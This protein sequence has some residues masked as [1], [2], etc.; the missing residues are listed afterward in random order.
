MH[1]LEGPRNGTRV[2]SG[3][4]AKIIDTHDVAEVG[5]C[6]SHEMFDD[7]RVPIHRASVGLAFFTPAENARQ[8]RAPSDRPSLWRQLRL[9]HQRFGR[10]PDDVNVV[11]HSWERVWFLGEIQQFEDRHLG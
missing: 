10:I 11:T 6:N 7:L 4:A 3:E 2:S 5:A 8:H 9:L 1:H